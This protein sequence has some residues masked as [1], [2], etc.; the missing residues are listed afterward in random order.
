[1]HVLGFIQVEGDTKRSVD[2]PSYT[3]MKKGPSISEQELLLLQCM[4]VY[5]VEKS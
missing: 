4:Q 2:V 5:R 3:F 1:M